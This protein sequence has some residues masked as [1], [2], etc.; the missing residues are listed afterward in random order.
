MENLNILLVEDNDMDIL[1]TKEILSTSRIL[2]TLNIVSTAEE[3][4]SYVNQWAPFQQIEKPE[5]ILLDIN[6]PFGNGFGVLV[7]VKENPEIC[8]IPVVI[9]T[10]STCQYDKE[11]ALKNG[12]DYYMEK[13]LDIPALKTFLKEGKKAVELQESLVTP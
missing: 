3:A 4:I 7:E 2:Q 6:L 12:A 10:S 11:F 1:I 9:L 5:L 8:D 13:P